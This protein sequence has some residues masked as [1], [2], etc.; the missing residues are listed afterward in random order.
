[1]IPHFAATGSRLRGAF[2]IASILAAGV[3]LP[4]HAQG[5]QGDAPTTESQTVSL[6]SRVERIE[7]HPIGLDL[8]PLDS[9]IRGGHTVQAGERLIGRVAVTGGTLEVFGTIDGNAIALDGDVVVR[10]GGMIR[11]DALA[12]GGRVRV[13]GGIIEGEM[14][15]LSGIGAARPAGAVAAEQSPMEATQRAVSLA[16][17]WLMML[18][19]IGIGVLMFAGTHLQAV[20]EALERRFAR[21]FWTGLLGQL[22]LAPVLFLLLVGLALTLIGILLIPFAVVAY[23]LLVAG[24][25]TLGFLAV[26]RRTGGALLRTGARGPDAERR[27]RLRSLM[28][29]ILIYAGLWLLAGAFA[30][31]P[32]IGGAL[33]GLAVVV[34]WAALTVGLGAVLMTRAGTRASPRKSVSD[35]ELEELAWTTPTPVSGVAAARRPT[36]V[37][38]TE[39]R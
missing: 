16:L 23:T 36:P 28:V 14:R 37:R 24:L 10:E 27:A 21:S 17:G 29:G 35:S 1:M 33:R 31:S 38:A 2:G 30:W 7:Q 11:G 9:I 5:N 12:V 18:A 3:T 13:E 32:I 34:T 15:S 26:A 22:A 4:L 39:H 25:L 19:I 8:P 20:E 6:E